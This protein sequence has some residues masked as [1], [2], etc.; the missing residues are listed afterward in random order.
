M[1]YHHIPHI[2]QVLWG[3]EDTLSFAFRSLPKNSVL[4]LSTVGSYQLE[5]RKM[6]TQGFNRLIKDLSPKT[7][8][9]YGE[10]Y[11]LTFEKYVEQVIYFESEWAK[12]RKK[13][14][15]KKYVKI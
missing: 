13:I 2:P 14:K 9:V 7:L 6:F 4:L 15:E 10:F 8:L 5:S 1:Q 12:I 3:G 11:P